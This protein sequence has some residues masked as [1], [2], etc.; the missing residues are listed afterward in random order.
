MK[1]NP[2]IWLVAGQDLNVR[3][4]GYEPNK[5]HPRNPFRIRDLAKAITQLGDD[6]CIGH[7]GLFGV[8]L[9]CHGNVMVT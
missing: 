2:L 9:E 3:P 4:S 8:D 1:R 5:A 6:N 7:F